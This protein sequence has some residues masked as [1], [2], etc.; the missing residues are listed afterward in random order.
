MNAIQKL[1]YDACNTVYRVVFDHVSL[2]LSHVQKAA[3]AGGIGGYALTFAAVSAAKRLM[4]EKAFN[5]LAKTAVYAIPAVALAQAVFDP[6]GTKEML[7][8]QQ[9]FATGIGLA[10][11]GSETAL[12]QQAFAKPKT[13]EEKLV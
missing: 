4:P 7:E 9:V 2:P 1:V 11:L 10:M 13:L 3:L 5:I 12:A 8:H 6:Q